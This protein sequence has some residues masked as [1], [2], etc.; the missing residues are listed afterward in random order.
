MHRTHNFS[1]GP[2]AL[3]TEVLQQASEEMLDYQSSGMSVMEMSHRS[4][5]LGSLGTGRGI[6]GKQPERGAAH[7]EGG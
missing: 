7:R 5:T 4:A 1:A 3:P 2:A 6:L